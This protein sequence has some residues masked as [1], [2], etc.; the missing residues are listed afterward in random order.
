MATATAGYQGRRAVAMG[1]HGVMTG[2]WLELAENEGVVAEGRMKY[3]NV[4]C[5]GAAI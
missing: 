3:L 4:V 2:A 1:G 5:R